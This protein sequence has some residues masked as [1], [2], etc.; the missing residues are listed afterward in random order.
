MATELTPG[1]FTA[2]FGRLAT[3]AA[4]VG[5]GA[6]TALAL[7]IEREAKINLGL[8]QHSRG[9]KTTA[10]KGG[11]PALVSGTLRRSVTHTRPEMTLMGWEVRVG[12]ATGFY[13]PYPKKGRRTMSSKYGAYLELVH[14]YPFLEPAFRKVVAAGGTAQLGR[15][16]AADWNR[17]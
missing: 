17:T 14:D 10:S 11:P 7:A 2:I 16:L 8:H 3:R 4:A 6:L 12:L 9:T 15:L 5:P 13:P 1:V